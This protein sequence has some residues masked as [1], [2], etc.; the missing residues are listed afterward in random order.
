MLNLQELAQHLKGVWH[1]NPATP[2]LAISS[3]AKA[4]A[5]DV[6]GYFNPTQKELLAITQAGAVIL[7]SQDLSD[8]QGNAIVVDN[9]LACMQQLTRDFPAARSPSAGIHPSAIISAS[10]VLGSRVQIDAGAWIGEAVSL[11]EGVRIGANA[12]IES[13]VVIGQDAKIGAGVIVHA[14]CRIGA[15]VQIDYGAVIGAS[16]FN[17][18]KDRGRW[19]AG[20]DLGAVVIGD[21]SR[22]GANTTIDRGGLADTLIGRDVCIDNLVQIAHDVCIG[23]NSAIA[24]C[25]AIGAFAQLGRD[26]VVGG[27]ACIA[28][29]VQLTDDVVITGMSTVAKSIHKAGIYS[30]G[31][32]VSEHQRW[33]RNAARFRRLD[34]YMNR[35]F[36]L[37]MTQNKGDV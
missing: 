6:A 2:L 18:H 14:G 26:C 11:A 4:R 9:P 34:D 3:L 25:A 22:I 21:H 15:Q 20:H 17:V 12:V 7:T 5:T 8:Y 31:T 36:E 13:G 33:R 35:L 19:N 24:G 1:G 29:S 32:L 16:P 30:S 27:A 37:E 10:A 28:A 23:D